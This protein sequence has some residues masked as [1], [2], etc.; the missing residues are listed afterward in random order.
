MPFALRRPH[1]RRSHTR[2]PLAVAVI[3]AGLLGLTATAASA[4]VTVKPDVTAS[5]GYAELVFRIPNESPSATTTKVVLTLPQV[6]PFTEVSVEPV[7]GWDVT[8]TDAPLP[9][10]ATV[11]GTTISKAPRVVT[12]AAAGAA[13]I[14]PGPN[15]SF[16]ISAGPLPAPG[17]LE[18]PVAQTYSDRSVVAWTDPTTKG[19]AEPEHPAPHVEVTAAVDDIDHQG[20][21]PSGT[22]TA[23]APLSSTTHATSDTTSRWFSGA[24]LVVA[25]GALG[26]Q[27]VG[28]RRQ[29]G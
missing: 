1:T 5:G 23:A 25:P 21:A 6:N 26:L 29:D 16:A 8:V 9:S 10:P 2:R 14:A 13:A 12:A 24:A 28:R 27:L 11:D 20:G 4:H 17:T 22:D 18:L 19:A 3:A 7:P 15:Q